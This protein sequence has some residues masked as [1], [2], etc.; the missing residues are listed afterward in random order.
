M[1]SPADIY[2]ER[3]ARFGRERNAVTVRW[4]RVSNVRLV[5]FLIAIGAL[6]WGVWAGD[7][8]LFGLLGVALFIG[9]VALAT[10]HG[11]LGRQRQRL[12]DLVSINDEALLRYERDWDR[13]PLRHTEPVDAGHPYALDLDVTGRASLMHLLLATPSPIGEETLRS[14]LLVLADRETVRE[15]QS[16]AAELRDE[17]DLRDDLAVHG[18]RIRTAR[19]DVGPFLAWAE[20]TPWL[21]P[22]RGVR[23]AAR[24]CP[25]FFWVFVIAQIT[26]LV[27]YPLWVPFLAANVILYWRLGGRAYRTLT[28]LWEQAGAFEHYAEAMQIIVD[29]PSHSAAL[30]R[31]DASLRAGGRSAPA[32]MRRLDRLTALAI[33]RSAALYW[34]IQLTTLWDIHALNGLEGWQEAAGARTR[35]WLR[36]LGEVEALAALGG[37]SFDNPDWVF[38]D[39]EP[40]ARLL[41]ARSLGHPLL[42]PD[43]RV[44]NDVEVGPAGTFLFATGSNMSGKS[45][46]LRAIGVNLVLAGAGAPVCARPFRAPPVTL[47]TSMRVQ[48]SLERGVSYF[49]AELQRLKQ[50]V[51]AARDARSEGRVLFYLLDEIL[52][53]TNTA[54]RQT[55]A[56]R[57]IRHLLA[58]GALGAVSTHDLSLADAPDLH[59]ASKPVHLTESIVSV[60]NDSTMSFD[61]KLRPGIAT[62][63]NALRLMAIVGLDLEDEESGSRLD[64][65]R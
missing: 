17:I 25:F 14:W 34:P 13:L 18:R 61:Y 35:G 39:P 23:W 54:E 11:I 21:R 62:S 22:L 50:I 51:D 43:A 37:L 44:D 7:G 48:D 38:P 27:P 8:N 49:M 65:C 53:G 41:V 33:P 52:Q 57:V 55:A 59:A 28:R 26:G 32:H 20:G 46:L 16:G 12:S 24:L 5:V 36:A 31:I 9:Y 15:R 63:S 45:T 2:R 1:D 64:T 6:L 47:W 40:T 3:A 56:R 10:Y 4:E 42:P 58:Q 19:P 29:A 60:A 30:K